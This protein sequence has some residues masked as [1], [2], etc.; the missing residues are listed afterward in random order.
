MFVQAISQI[1][2]WL[3]LHEL[4]LALGGGLKG[5]VTGQMLFPAGDLLENSVQRLPLEGFFDLV[6][7]VH[8]R[9]HALHFALM[10]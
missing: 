4:D 3:R 7:V 1:R 5:E 8:H 2:K 9:P 10:F 6:D